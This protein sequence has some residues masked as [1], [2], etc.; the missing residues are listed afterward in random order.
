MMNSTITFA[1]LRHYLLDL[2]FRELTV[3]DS[4]VA[5]EHAGSGTLI[6]LRPYQPEEKL[7][8]WHLAAVRRALVDNGF[9]KL[10]EFNNLLQQ[11]AV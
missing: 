3:P 1:A 8:L 10:E 6:V 11:K 4:H 7:S 2:G 9:V 5:F